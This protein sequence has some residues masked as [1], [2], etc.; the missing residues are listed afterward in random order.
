M[1]SMLRIRIHKLRG[2]DVQAEHELRQATA[3]FR[4]AAPDFR[5]LAPFLQD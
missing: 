1:K 3:E 5:L 4:L 2:K